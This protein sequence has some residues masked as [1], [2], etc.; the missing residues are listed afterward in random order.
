MD[1]TYKE[2]LALRKSLL[3]EQRDI[4][5][6]VNDAGDPRVRAAVSEL[7]TWLLGT[8]LPGRYPSMFKLHHQAQLGMGKAPLLENL[9]TTEVWPVVPGETDPTILALE[10]LVKVVDEDFLILLPEQKEK[11]AGHDAGEDAKYVLEAYSNCFPAGFNPREKLGLRLASIHGPVP[12]Y[13]EKL[14]RSMDRFF[15]KIEVGRYVRRF[16][17]GI[18][19]N[20]KLFAAFGG[21]HGSADEKEE[22]MKPGAL[23]VDRVRLPSLPLLR[24]KVDAVFPA[25]LLSLSLSRQ[26]LVRCERQTL[27]RLPRSKALVF[28]F[29][30]YTYPIQ[31][32]KDEGSGEDL[33]Q[34]IDGLKEGS[35]P[36]MHFYK[37]G[38]VWGEAVKAFLR[39]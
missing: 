5:V 1:N 37:R 28:S 2:R 10:T 22:P 36:Q 11:A 7:Y 13:S 4:V 38:A 16:N 8:Y 33:A 39:S 19:T 6:A 27:H 20:T 26:T 17:W 18:T 24:S 25:D 34:A 29:H 30:T 9:V 14:E 21:T 32:I 23:D 3:E 12:H 31:S 15:S 35:A